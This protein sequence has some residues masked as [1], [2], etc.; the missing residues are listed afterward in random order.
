MS[1]TRHAVIVSAARTP[2]GSF[3][4]ALS[5]IPAT[6]LGSVAISEVLKR[7]DLPGDRVDEVYMGC[8]LAAGLGQA[9]ARQASMGA[10]IPPSVGA[11]TVNKVCGSSLKTVLMASQ[12]IGMGEA[13][14]IVAGGME[15]MSLAPYLSKK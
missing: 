2:L 15:S 13:R 6:K 1:D 14:I 8:V 9:P 5:S 4:G 10:G 7:I 12:A 3:Q 11:T